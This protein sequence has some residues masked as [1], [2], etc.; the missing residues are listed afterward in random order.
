MA[1][2][3]CSEIVLMKSGEI[4]AVG[5]PKTVLTKERMRDVYDIDV[6]VMGQEVPII[7]PV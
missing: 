7:V 4:V 2:R 5:E 3:F 1:A 6:N